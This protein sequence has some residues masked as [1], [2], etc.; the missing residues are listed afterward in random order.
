MNI[1]L[2]ELLIYPPYK[3]HSS[4]IILEGYRGSQAH[5]TF[6]QGH[7]DSTDQVDRKVANSICTFLVSDYFRE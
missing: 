7:P 2:T 4:G 5:G 1:D 3:V 6:V